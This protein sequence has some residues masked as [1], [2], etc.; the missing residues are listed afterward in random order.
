MTLSDIDSK[1]SHTDFTLFKDQRDGF[2]SDDSAEGNVTYLQAPNYRNT[3][4]L[5]SLENYV[6]LCAH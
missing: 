3:R 5:D 6:E 1:L 2:K 4:D